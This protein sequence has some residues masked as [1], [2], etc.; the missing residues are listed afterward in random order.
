MLR[1]TQENVTD[2]C[3]RLNWNPLERRWAATHHCPQLAVLAVFVSIPVAAHVIKLQKTAEVGART[4]MG[5]RSC[6]LA[7]VSVADGQVGP[8]VWLGR[9]WIDNLVDSWMP[10]DLPPAAAPWVDGVIAPLANSTLKTALRL[11]GQPYV[12]PEIPVVR[13]S[14]K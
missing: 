10:R 4:G 2:I 13:P 1:L 3:C 8:S 14:A 9:V 11:G 7:V 5:C 6:L 12:V